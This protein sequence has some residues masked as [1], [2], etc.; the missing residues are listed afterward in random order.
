MAQTTQVGI[1]GLPL[2]SSVPL[3]KLLKVCIC[4]SPTREIKPLGYVSVSISMSM[5]LS[6]SI[7]IYTHTHTHTH[8]YFKEL[9]K[10]MVW[11]H[12]SKICFLAIPAAKIPT[13][14]HSSCPHF[15][16]KLVLEQ[17]QLDGEQFIGDLILSLVS[18][19]PSSSW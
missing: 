16:C 6:V 12:T 9:P 17:F 15:S 1:V 10:C 5:P 7:S 4:Q 8:N 18:S 14:G 3:S 2:A 11:Q 19:L 13:R